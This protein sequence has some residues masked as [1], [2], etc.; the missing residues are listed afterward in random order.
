MF[1][2]VNYSGHGI[3]H[4]YQHLAMMN[5]KVTKEA[6]FN[7]EYELREI[8]RQEKNIRIVNF[9]NCC[10][11]SITKFEN[12]AIY[13]ELLKP[14]NYSTSSTQISSEELQEDPELRYIQLMMSDFG[15]KADVDEKNAERFVNY[16]NQFAET[17]TR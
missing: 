13:E 15:G 16:S 4:N 9:L 12:S 6:F 5:S 11:H 10:S 3:T 2:F 17:C 1:L 14:E 8:A 7:I